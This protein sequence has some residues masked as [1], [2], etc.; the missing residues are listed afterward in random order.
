MKYYVKLDTMTWAPESVY[1]RAHD[2]H[3]PCVVC[4]EAESRSAAVAVLRAALQRLVDETSEQT[5]NERKEG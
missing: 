4:V 5:S 2:T 1:D 3:D